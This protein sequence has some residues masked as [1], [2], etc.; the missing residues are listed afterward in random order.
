MVK[1]LPAMQ[2]T[3]VGSL[4]WEDTLEEGIA[5]HSNILV[6]RIPQTEELSGL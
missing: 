6:W 1:N 4:G 5:T 3:W 2:E